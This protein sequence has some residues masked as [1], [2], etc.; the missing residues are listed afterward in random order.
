MAEDSVLNPVESPRKPPVPKA[1]A[2]APAP[3]AKQEAAPTN[4]AEDPVDLRLNAMDDR[5][6]KMMGMIEKI[7]QGPTIMK[8]TGGYDARED[9][10]AKDVDIDYGKPGKVESEL[11]RPNI[12][13]EKL[14]EIAEFPVLCSIA[15]AKGE[16]ADAMRCSIN[17]QDKVIPLNRQVVLETKFVCHLAACYAAEFT[18]LGR[19]RD[20]F[21]VPENE[22][23]HRMRVT[24]GMKYPI[25]ITGKHESVSNDDFELQKLLYR[26]AL[27]TMPAR[28]GEVSVAAIA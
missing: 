5:L 28:Y 4:G 27:N 8:R 18:D 14:G 21:S 1:R 15:P 2:N 13:V 17:G 26:Q 12:P 6:E 19:A 10:R 20:P 25:H 3:Q 22:N 24:R 16:E 11:E 23:H 9:M 7:A